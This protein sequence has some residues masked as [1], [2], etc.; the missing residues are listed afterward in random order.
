MVDARRR[1]RFT[2]GQ[3]MIV[4]AALAVVF[5]SMPMPLAIDVA[6]A[7]NLPRRDRSQSIADSTGLTLLSEPV[8]CIFCFFGLLAVGGVLGAWLLRPGTIADVDPC[9]H[10]R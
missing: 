1:F 4:I 9:V 7:D 3:G 6:F 10:F 5:A 8:G 2:I